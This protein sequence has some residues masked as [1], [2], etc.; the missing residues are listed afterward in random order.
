MDE[1][2][3]IRPDDWHLHLRDGSAMEAILPFSA[4]RFGRA[5]V[6]PNLQPPVTTVA[7]ARDYRDRILAALPPGSPFEPLMTLYLTPDTDPREIPHAREAGVHAVKLYPAGATTHSEAGVTSL[8]PLSPVFAAMEEAGLPLLVHGEVTDPDVDVFD[9]EAVFIERHLA[10]LV[11]RFPGLPVVLE[12]V[13]T[14]DGVAFVQEAREG[15]A[16]T[17]T[18]HHLLINR[19]HLL[20]GGIRP[21]L[22]CAPVVKAESHRRALV[23]AATSGSPRFFLG[24]DSAPHARADKETACGCAGVFTAHAALELYA[25]AFDAA[26]ALDRLEDF[27]SRNGPAFYG[28]P[29]NEDKVT[30]RRESWQVPARLPYGDEDLVPLRAAESVAWRLVTDG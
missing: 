16:G 29:A 8:E 2:T 6:M 17:V 14:A 9:R 5:I 30:L 25:E 1:I 7:R 18:A 10:A 19:N 12:H 23:D 13:T 15:V 28:L 27:A 21:H 20:A 4:E 22:Y 24:T 3:I 26:D 11:T